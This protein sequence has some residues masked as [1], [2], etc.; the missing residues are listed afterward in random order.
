MYEQVIKS[1]L[2]LY[3]IQIWKDIKKRAEGVETKNNLK[4]VK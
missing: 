1:Y 3:R 4:S 2:F